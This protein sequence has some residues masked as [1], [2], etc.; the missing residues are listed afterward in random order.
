[1]DS[2]ND[3]D[4]ETEAGRRDFEEELNRFISIYPGAIVKE[5]ETVNLKEFYA[6]YAIT[7]GEDTSKFDSNLVEKLKGQLEKKKK[8]DEIESGKGTEKHGDHH[9]DKVIEVG[10]EY[11]K[12][13]KSKN[14]KV[15]M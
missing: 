15:L 8:L 5:G 12:L 1:M 13:L 3:Y 9:H 4:V 11:P 10:T 2:K 14:K 6:I 7:R